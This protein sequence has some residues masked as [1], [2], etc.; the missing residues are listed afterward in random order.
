MK[1]WKYLLIGATILLVGSTYFFYKYDFNL[2]QTETKIPASAAIEV[3]L[4]PEINSLSLITARD[5]LIHSPVYDAAYIGNNSYNFT[6]MFKDVKPIIESYDIAFYNQESIIG[7]KA[8]GLSTYPRFN[9]PEEIGEATIDAGFDL[10]SLA[11]NHTLDK[12]ETGILNSLNYWSTKENIMTAGS[13]T[14]EAN[15][16][17]IQIGEVNGI[18][19]TLLSYTTLTNG[20]TIPSGKD[21]LVN[22]YS[23]AKAKEDIERVRDKVDIVLVSMHWGTEYTLDQIDS[24]E[25][26]AEFLSEQGV[27]VVIGHHPHVIEPIEYIGDTL[28]IYS[29]GNFIS[30]QYRLGMDKAVGA[31]VSVNFEKVEENGISKVTI[32][33]VEATLTYNYKNSAGDYKIYPFDELNNSIL[34][35]YETHYNK[36]KN[37]IQKLDKTIKVTALE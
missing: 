18:T 5:V 24:Q 36:Y 7:G 2:F 30:N 28:V 29:L 31:M 33:D 8:L 9:S 25:E 17:K 22:V 35:N 27:D 12:G 11:N 3:N 16:E 23:E 15:R 37:V 21:Y 34:S 19:Y 14:S 6:P 10:V 20:L 26:I 4:T 1:P 13:Y 32:T